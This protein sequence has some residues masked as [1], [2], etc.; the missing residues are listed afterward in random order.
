MLFLWDNGGRLQHRSDPS[1]RLQRA[2]RSPYGFATFVMS[3]LS[4]PLFLS[5]GPADDKQGRVAASE[6]AEP[7]RFLVAAHLI[8]PLTDLTT[9]FSSIVPALP[10]RL[11]T[12][13]DLNLS[14]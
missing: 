4:L 13:H 10:V 2:A 3:C 9:L 11:N 5:N 12:Q 6:R 8:A 1:Q 7:A 14:R